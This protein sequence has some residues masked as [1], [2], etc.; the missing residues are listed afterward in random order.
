M[1]KTIISI[2]L[3]LCFAFVATAQDESVSYPALVNKQGVY[4]LPEQGDFALGIDALPILN[5]FG[6]RGNFDQYQIYGK[7]FLGDN[8]ALR[9]K[10]RV[11]VNND[12][13]KYAVQNDQAVYANPLDVDATVIDVHNY[14]NNNVN[15]SIGYEMRRGHG[16]VQGFFGGELNLGL[17][18][19]KEKFEYANPITEL[20]PTP[21][22][23]YWWAYDNTRPTEYKHGNT[24]SAGLGLFVGAEYFIAPKLSIGAEL[25]LA[26]MFYKEDMGEITQEFWNTTNNKLDTRTRR[27]NSSP[28]YSTNP[29]REHNVGFNT[30]PGGSVYFM[31]HF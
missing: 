27:E 12:A 30:K 14:S 13:D 26:F 21:S 23:Y 15:L 29:W 17:S 7:Y 31:F 6:G 2:G 16:R 28:W 24:Y 25:S 11:G 4:I 22:S 1:K 5:L 3:C 20:N 19:G 18:T 9:V 10:L 8:S